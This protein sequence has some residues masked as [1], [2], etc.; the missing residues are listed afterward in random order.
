LHLRF[1][2]D[3]QRNAEIISERLTPE[4]I[5]ALE[6]RDPERFAAMEKNCDNLI[7]EDLTHISGNQLFLCGTG[8]GSFAVGYDGTF[9]LC[10]SLWAP[11]T[12][13]D[14]RQV[15]LREAWENLVP[16]VRDLRSDDPLFLK[17]CRKCPLV[18]LCIWCP[19]HAYLETGAMD[20]ETPYFCQVAHARAAALQT[21]MSQ[22]RQET[23]NRD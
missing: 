3:P 2:G 5:V 20:G 18:N 14:L 23:I 17:T 16:A 1:D 10:F 11:G 8:N 7:N 15:S 19:A 4:G 6:Q 13:V 22:S 21:K 12:T 9:R